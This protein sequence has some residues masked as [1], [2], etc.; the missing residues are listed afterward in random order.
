MPRYEIGNM[1][2]VYKHTN[3]FLITT[4]CT[5]DSKGH[6][7]MGAGIAFQAKLIHPSLPEWAGR[8]IRS[9]PNPDRY[10]TLIRQNPWRIGLFQVKD[11]WQKPASLDLIRLSTLMLHHYAIQNPSTRI[12]LNLPGVGFGRLKR[13]DVIPLLTS[14]PE[15]VH[16]WEIKES[17]G[18]PPI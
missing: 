15:N 1:W 16:I 14:L 18:R 13:D 7:V 17:K 8:Q 2:S 4:N 9:L 10:G 12:D 11:H 6:L 3:L 5:L